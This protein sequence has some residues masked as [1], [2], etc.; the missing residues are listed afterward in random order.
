MYLSS[1]LD[2][3]TTSFEKERSIATGIIMPGNKTIFRNGRIGM[4]S[5]TL[6]LNKLLTSPS[7]S[8]MRDIEA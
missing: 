6:I 4:F 3:L 1:E 5:S 2:I 8:A 7:K